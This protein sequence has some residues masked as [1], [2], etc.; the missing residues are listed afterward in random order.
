[1][2][3][4]SSKRLAGFALTCALLIGVS[5][6]ASTE[7]GLTTDGAC[8]TLLTK[9][10]MPKGG[11]SLKVYSARQETYSL[12]ALTDTSDPTK[13]LAYKHPT[14]ILNAQQIYQLAMNHYPS[15]T[16]LDPTYPIK[17]H[18]YYSVFSD[19]VK[20]ADGA[21]IIG[22]YQALSELV[23]YISS[24]S[25]G[26]GL[27]FVGPGGTG[28]TELLVILDRLVDSL[29]TSNPDHFEYTFRWKNLDKIPFLQPLVAD[30]FGNLHITTMKRSPLTLLPREI[31]ERIVGVATERV[32]GML[33]ANPR[34][35]LTPDPQSAEIIN[36]IVEFYSK[37]RGLTEITE[38]DYISMLEQHVDIVRRLPDPTMPP[39]IIR[40]QDKHADPS[41]LFFSENIYLK[42]MYGQNSALSYD[43]N[44]VVPRRDGRGVFFDE[45]FRNSEGLL[46]T[47]LEV[48]QNSV[49]EAGGAPPL[50]LNSLFLAATN[51]ESIEKARTQFAIKANLD[52]IKKV[53]MR[54]PIHPGM[55]ASIAL[56]MHSKGNMAQMYKM[57][58]VGSTEMVPAEI[59]EIYTLPNERG[60]IFGPE[61]RVAL[62]A[63]PR[64]SKTILISP[65][66]LELLGLTVAA[67]RM[68]TDEKKLKPFINELNAVGPGSQYFTSPRSRLEVITRRVKEVQKPVLF[69]LAR[70]NKL[71]HEGEGGISARDVERWL[72]HALNIADKS[73]GPLTPLVMDQAFRELI[74][75]GG[76]VE[77]TSELRSTWIQIHNAVKSDFLLADITS[78]VQTIIGSGNSSAVQL[79]NDIRE[80]AVVLATNADAD[81]WSDA[82]GTRHSIN[83]ERY[84]EI[85]NIYADINGEPFTPG[86][87]TTFDL[88]ND[89]GSVYQPLMRAVEKYMLKRQLDTTAITGIIDHLSGKDVSDDV[90]EQGERVSGRL[91]KFGYDAASFKQAL[92]FI[93]DEQFELQRR[94]ASAQ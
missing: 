68:V 71:L 56:L 72:S 69:E 75:T 27:M 84:A 40:F 9:A 41:Q 57:R 11:N 2:T 83:R 79:Y 28:K 73:G 13:N 8:V 94:Q 30:D 58:P 63:T 90:R 47:L 48:I 93:R 6:H 22:Q 32:R 81:Y 35:F 76:F 25:S 70:V 16:I 3:N 82:S 65:H 78:D 42:Q 1:M 34:P 86:R 38:E 12:R 60:E 80:E 43:Y 50:I 31:Q 59:N 85:A 49:L 44:G 51:D 67:T 29:S 54:Q 18:N 77:N 4:I 7:G 36:A 46:N 33:D 24:Q 23:D 64:L 91:A 26:K 5:A 15:R 45:C 17:Q 20:E 55:I 89:G 74:D 10:H 21:S 14:I 37:E 87:V 61:G 66:A 62:Y 39:G 88:K 53:P 52:R 92:Q 19:G